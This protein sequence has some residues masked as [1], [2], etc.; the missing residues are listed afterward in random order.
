[1]KHRFD[2][3]Q[4]LV[5]NFWKR[6]YRDVFPNVII[7]QKWHIQK[8][9]LMVNVV[10]IQDSN[11]VQGNYKMGI[12][13]K[14]MPSSDGLVRRVLESYKN[15]V[16]GIDY[17]GKPYITAEKSVYDLIAIQAADELVHQDS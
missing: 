17:K 16:D 5:E 15:N 8:R 14:I 1:M 13:K 7:R 10:M 2:F 9:N 4:R 11:A 6:W 12:V 3:I